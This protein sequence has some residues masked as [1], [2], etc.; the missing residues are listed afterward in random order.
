MRSRGLAR[1]GG[2]GWKQF[3][4]GAIKREAGN[5]NALAAELLG[6]NKSGAVDALDDITF[7]MVP[8]VLRMVDEL[9]ERS[10]DCSGGFTKV[11][12]EERPAGFQDTQYIPK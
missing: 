12:D 8:D 5:Q 9:Y 1:C 2:L 11:H 3:F 6:A 4:R 10:P 7:D